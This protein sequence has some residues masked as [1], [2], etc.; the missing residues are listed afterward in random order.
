[1][2]RLKIILLAACFLPIGTYAQ[3]HKLKSTEEQTQHLVELRQNFSFSYDLK[4]NFDLSLSEEIRSSVYDNMSDPTAYFSK[5]YTTVELGYKPLN[6]Q[7]LNSG[8]TYGLKFFLGYTLRF[9]ATK[10]LSDPNKCLQHRPY[11]SAVGSVNFGKLKLSL[12]ERYQVD[13]RCDSVSVID[14]YNPSI[15]VYEKNP[16]MME[17]RSRL[18][19]DYSIPGK[20]V[21]PYTYIELT[22]TLNE[23]SCPWLDAEGKP[24]YGGQY[25]SSV[26]VGAG[27][28]W[29]IDS[30]NALELQY[31]FAC[32]KERDVNI[33]K[34]AQNVEITNTT[35]FR[36][37]I[38]VAY[39]LG[40]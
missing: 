40:Y 16:Y 3:Q 15:L 19:L 26:R 2:K 8:Y 36:H 24:L 29:R 32:M 5:S 6:I 20:P 31:L 33:T 28:K 11:V 7:S 21:K 4:K 23:P 27:V 14:K 37:S 1:M 10:D 22:N 12:R 39:D 34:A 9:L 38:T 18:R 30:H 17:L 25:L 13:I 35:A